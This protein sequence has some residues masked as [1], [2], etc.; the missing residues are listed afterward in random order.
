M[1]DK[2]QKIMSYL[3]LF[4]MLFNNPATI[5]LAN[6]ETAAKE[7]VTIGSLNNPGDI[8]VIK[9][10]KSIDNG[11]YEITFNVKSKAKTT[12][13]PVYATV[14]F[15][16][17]GSMICS[18]DYGSE[19]NYVTTFIGQL[20]TYEAGD[21]THIK[22]SRTLPN[23]SAFTT[24]KWENAI[25]GAQTFNTKIKEVL[26]DNAHVSL[27][28]FSSDASRLGEVSEA[29]TDF[30][31]A[32][33]GHPRGGT[34]LDKAI[35]A[36]TTQ[37]NNEA[38]NDSNAKKVMLIISD[39]S[40]DS[41]S[42]T[43]A[44]ANI[45][46]NSTN[47]IEIYAIGYETTTETSQYLKSLASKASNYSNANANSIV[48]AIEKMAQ[49]ITSIAGAQIIEVP[50]SPAFT[51]KA[52]ENVNNTLEVDSIEGDIITYKPITFKLKID[53][54]LES[55]IYE[56]NNTEETKIMLDDEVIFDIDQSPSVEWT[57]PKY[58]YTVN[59]YK[60]SISGELIDT[61]LSE[62]DLLANIPYESKTV[63]GYEFYHLENKNGETV[64]NVSISN[65]SSNN[66]LNVIYKKKTNLE[67]K[68]YYHYQDIDDENVYSEEADSN[69]PFTATY[70]DVISNNTTKPETDK[71]FEQT[72]LKEGFTYD[73]STSSTEDTASLT[74]DDVDS[75]RL[76]LYYTRNNY[77]YCI[78]Y[79][80]DEVE[81]ETLR[82]SNVTSKFG[83]TISY[84]DNPNTGYNKSGYK[85][86][87]LNPTS[88]SITINAVG[89]NQNAEDVNLIEVYYV[90]DNINYTVN[91]Y[92][93]SKSDSN[94]LGETVTKDALFEST[95]TL[96]EEELNKEIL[97]GYK[98]QDGQ[99]TTLTI[100]ANP[101]NNNIDVIYVKDEF[102]YCVKYFYDEVEDTSKEVKDI[103]A[104][105]GE[106]ISY[107]DKNIIGY[108]FDRTDPKDGS[109]TVT[110]N[111]ESNILKVYYKK[112]QFDYTVEYYY[113][114]TKDDSKT[115]TKKA[116]YKD[117]IDSYTDKNIDGYKLDKVENSP[118]T[119]T[120][121]SKNNIIKVYYVKDEFD[122]IVEYYI[123]D[124]I[125]EEVIDKETFDETVVYY[126]YDQDGL[127]LI[128][129]DPEN[130]IIVISSDPSK[131]IIRV[132]YRSV[133]KEEPIEI[134]NTMVNGP[135][136]NNSLLYLLIILNV[137]LSSVYVTRKNN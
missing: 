24:E 124:E 6:A 123:D 35:E 59:Y 20:I 114:G 133:T 121:N 11:E 61:T 84:T 108:V 65:N 92:K 131:N 67:Y 33:F 39:G 109:I 134:P 60:D 31:L 111:P 29:T 95:V 112:G 30:S 118:L 32:S 7:S 96:T 51:L 56:T 64:S 103:K 115:E 76:D 63:K 94:K 132:Y 18:S 97:P 125:I 119:I 22:C 68:V 127:E 71:S 28:T 98:V 66:I 85:L 89:P 104:L 87:R 10:V 25:R 90:K 2:L 58:K 49:E 41:T 69:S 21:G 130:G 3:M 15:D 46:K 116:T 70:G 62:G 37:L 74:I 126:S 16:R 77:G 99:T 75:N 93:D 42:L 38:Q 52:E 40:P 80:Y 86:D 117:V 1:K 34:K 12:T 9:S 4:V 50:N 27:I 88:G 122:Y 102:N 54:T 110:E 73:H 36:A 23:Y 136:D 57:K 81:D 107:K 137:M 17:S 43:T 5:I 120:E 8:Q 82:V 19:S 44:A 53:E 79:F 128:G 78:K 101:E 100:T 72:G 91:Y 83:S 105:F 45:A 106:T 14:V 48:T 129:T 135:K 13:K 47:N 113:E 26:G 55:N